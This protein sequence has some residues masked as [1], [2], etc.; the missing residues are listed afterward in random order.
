METSCLWRILGQ[1][2]CQMIKQR[3][4]RE[5]EEEMDNG[6]KTNIKTSESRVA[7]GK[8]RNVVTLLQT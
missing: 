4:R 1:S 3:K 8:L 6:V 2:L 5:K 7:C